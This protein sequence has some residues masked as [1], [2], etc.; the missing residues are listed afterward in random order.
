MFRPA[1]TR[2][3][4]L[5]CKLVTLLCFVISLGTL[6]GLR[7]PGAGAS[8]GATAGASPQ[9]AAASELALTVERCPNRLTGSEDSGRFLLD[10]SQQLQ[11]FG[12]ET[13]IQSYET[14]M[15]THSN[16]MNR[17]T[18]VSVGGENLLAY[19]PVDD[20]DVTQETHFDL[21]IVAPYDVPSHRDVL[22][23]PG[24]PGHSSDTTATQALDTFFTTQATAGLLRF[25]QGYKG[26][27]NVALALV[28]GH[29]QLGAGMKA[30]MKDLAEEGRTVGAVLV[31]GDFLGTGDIPLVP[32]KST[33]VYIVEKLS[34]LAEDAGLNTFLAGGHS[35]SAWF[36]AATQGPP[37]AA[38]G[39]E[40]AVDDGTFLGEAAMADDSIPAVTLGLPTGNK[41][42]DIEHFL[43]DEEI[44]ERTQAVASLLLGFAQSPVSQGFDT[45]EG[46][47]VYGDGTPLGFFNRTYIMRSKFL[48]Y[49]G[50]AGSLLAVL[51]VL[52]TKPSFKRL[53]GLGWVVGATAAALIAQ[54]VRT[55]AFKDSYPAYIPWT[56]PAIPNYLVLTVFILLVTT[57]FL[58]LWAVRSRIANLP[59][60]A[61]QANPI[62]NSAASGVWGLSVMVVLS[63]AAGAAGSQNFP[64]VIL[65]LAGLTF[66]VIIEW[67]SSRRDRQPSAAFLW[68]RRALYLTPL[69]PAAGLM[70]ANVWTGFSPANFAASVCVGVAL[71]SVLSTMEFPKPVAKS[72][73]G[74]LNMATLAAPLAIVI[75]IIAARGS[76]TI[77]VLARV[78]EVFDYS[79]EVEVYTTK[80]IKDITPEPYTPK[81]GFLHG[82]PNLEPSAKLKTGTLRFRFASDADCAWATVQTQVD[83]DTSSSAKGSSRTII[84]AEADYLERPT[85]VSV[86]VKD[87]P[88]SRG[89]SAPFVLENLPAILE[90]MRSGGAPGKQYEFS[91]GEQIS[92]K[93]GYAVRFV[94]WYPSQS[95]VST[96]IVALSREL[97]TV[98]CTASA[99]Y[100]GQSYVGQRLVSPSTP[101]IRV[102]NQVI[103]KNRPL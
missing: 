54:G 74:L 50:L 90:S 66:A 85:L 81:V 4:A 43:D 58:R 62:G 56:N 1:K 84:S 103:V 89:K 2:F 8:A 12:W 16:A 78:D 67:L 99:H 98:N 20:F 45:A 70:K 5:R 19:K 49:A 17:T 30:L 42:T 36:R 59:G 79:P 21:L 41:F 10:V 77:P 48:F 82:L 15:Q 91:N 39:F 13:R 68:I 53:G 61:F 92:P 83:R 80:P 44:A 18:F 71:G 93:T 72:R 57:G 76:G 9:N 63:L 87:M 32:K 102:T 95:P 22:A 26:D 34:A 40:N 100:F 88:V 23:E 64:Q 7:T 35:H 29:Y 73:V 6:T 86:E 96:K 97:G 55:L 69:I 27:Q 46:G 51:F 47:L 65:A 101:Q 38:V 37:V 33:P 11:E 75:A 28:S 25:A 3:A 14:I 60:A 31:V 52:P 94:W 24:Q